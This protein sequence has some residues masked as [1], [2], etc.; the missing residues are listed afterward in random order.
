MDFTLKTY[1]RLLALWRREEIPVWG[2]KAWLERRP[3][4]GILLRHDVDRRPDQAVTM[5]EL[6]K[7]YGVLS[8]YYFRAT[9]DVFRPEVIQR[10]YQAGH[11]VGYHYE[12]LARCR[13][14][15]EKAWQCF[16]DNLKR[17]RESVPVET[18]AMHGSPLWPWD[19][20]D[21]WKTH[22]FR[23]LGCTAEA[24]LSVD[25]SQM[26]YATDSGRTW[27][28]TAANL[29]D[30]VPGAQPV[31]FGSTDELI[32]Y[33]RDHRDRLRLALTVH[34]ERWRATRGGWIAQWVWDKSVNGVKRGLHRF[35][36][37]AWQGEKH[38]MA[39]ETLSDGSCADGG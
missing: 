33:C 29:R 5:A 12:D 19:N 28:D 35:R 1:G 6:E 22:D 13:G 18:L 21:L 2:V 34:P 31:P 17:F 39:G 7:E 32:G 25:Y 16:Q 11:E 8:T 15:I 30:R 24:F 37:R 27:A 3:E 9:R 26:I 10:V 4:H 14:N 20:R 23:T 38:F 36:K